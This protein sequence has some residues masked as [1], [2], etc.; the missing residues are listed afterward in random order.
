M[1]SFSPRLRH[2]RRSLHAPLQRLRPAL[3]TAR[4]Q[5]AGARPGAPP[6]KR[7]GVARGGDGG[8]AGHAGADLGGENR[9]GTPGENEGQVEKKKTIFFPDQ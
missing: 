3:R 2:L 1:S 5:R 7:H 4:R 9:W 8:P 6:A